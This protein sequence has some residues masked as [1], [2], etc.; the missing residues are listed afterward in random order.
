[1][2]DKT[3]D[4]RTNVFISYSRKDRAKVEELQAALDHQGDLRLFR[5]TDDILPTEEWKPRLEALIGA[6]DTIIF[7]LSPHSTTSEVCLWELEYAESLNKRIIPIVVDEVDGKVPNVVSK[8]NYIFMTKQDEF[9]KGI[10]SI[11]AA[12]NL[13][14]DWIREHTRL[15]ELAGRWVKSVEIGAQPLRSKELDA[16]ENWLIAHPPNAPQPTE[17]QR[18]F[19]YE[20]RKAASRRQRWITGLSMAAFFVISAAGIFAFLQRGDAIIAREE[21]VQQ[22]RQVQAEQSRLIANKA[23]Q[24]LE[25]GR[26][27]SALQLAQYALPLGEDEGQ[28]PVMTQAVDAFSRAYATSHIDVIHMLR[29]TPAYLGR[30][31]DRPCFAQNSATRVFAICD[32]GNGIKIGRILADGSVDVQMVSIDQQTAIALS[33]DGKVLA[34]LSSP[35]R[36]RTFDVETL[37]QTSDF[38]LSAADR[39]P[40]PDRFEFFSPAKILMAGITET[41]IINASAQTV[42]PLAF[43]TSRQTSQGLVYY[44]QDRSAGT[45]AGQTYAFGAPGG[46]GYAALVRENGTEIVPL[47]TDASGIIGQ[48]HQHPNQPY[49]ALYTRDGQLTFVNLDENAVTAQVE[50]DRVD[51]SC[52]P[53]DAP[54]FLAL[55]DGTLRILD[56]TS[57]RVLWQENLP[58][59]REL[60]RTVPSF[61]ACQASDAS[62]VVVARG[63]V[64]YFEGN[65]S[66]PL[67]EYFGFVRKASFEA[68]SAA[69]LFANTSD[70]QTVS[71]LFLDGTFKRWTIEPRTLLWQEDQTDSRYVSGDLSSNADLRLRYL[72]DGQLTLHTRQ[73]GEILFER[74]IEPERAPAR[75]IADKSVVARLD[76]VEVF[77]ETGHAIF[78]LQ[79]NANP[80]VPPVRLTDGVMLVSQS[81]TH[82]VAFDMTKA[83]AVVQ[84]EN[85][86]DETVSHVA[87]MINDSV[88]FLCADGRVSLWDRAQGVRRASNS[89]QGRIYADIL[90][91]AP[92]QS[93]VVMRDD[94][95]ALW[96]NYLDQDKQD[97]L[98]DVSGDPDV[99][100]QNN[101]ALFVDGGDW[102]VVGIDIDDPAHITAEWGV[103]G[104]GT[105]QTQFIG[106][107]QYFATLSK[108]GVL[109]IVNFE[110]SN[111]VQILDAERLGFANDKIVRFAISQDEAQV[112]MFFASGLVRSDVLMPA[113]LDQISDVIGEAFQNG[114]ALTTV[115]LCAEGFLA[116]HEC[117]GISRS[118]YFE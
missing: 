73:S 4:T 103:T 76:N 46:N 56:M 49:G 30:S 85:L 18:Q 95:N 15:G 36:L 111:Q 108:N 58:E 74:M 27:D 98:L 32:G 89:L 45:L 55:G 102:H 57:G 20:S 84:I 13:D 96:I 112:H 34:A 72:R 53:T 77:D 62:L 70:Q 28:R 24:M 75:L 38:Q 61:I 12:I 29:E 116:T 80:D 66:D 107:T 52:F 6:S 63:M 3:S 60:D 10:A 31:I 14:I 47:Q 100:A 33:P 114:S 59:G 7:A 81:E 82:L 5:D 1:M 117:M 68:P 113:P 101:R 11:T 44:L 43:Q 42:E 48:L 65:L 51:Q 104:A 110:T 41:M 25:Q 91:V 22:R 99:Q 67:D 16:A 39:M 92:D 9:N 21:A 8:L 87:N 19:I 93:Y 83:N 105:V 118:V 26:M 79:Y 23:T 50:I 106:D 94:Q 71:V 54:H 78:S 109:R 88:A 64:H 37:D 35:Y 2:N 69:P 17:A 40:L 86:C 90:A 97:V 115:E